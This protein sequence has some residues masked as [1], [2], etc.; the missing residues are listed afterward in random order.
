LALAYFQG[1][2]PLEPI[3]IEDAQVSS[4][5]AGEECQQQAI[6]A[7]VNKVQWLAQR[8]RYQNQDV[9]RSSGTPCSEMDTLIIEI[10]EHWRAED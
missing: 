3:D 1:Y 8:A 9:E 6:A 2:E 5:A 7:A 4:N 10:P